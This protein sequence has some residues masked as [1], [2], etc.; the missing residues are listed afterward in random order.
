MVGG[1]WI[2]SWLVAWLVEEGR[3]WGLGRGEVS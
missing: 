2:G 3:W 1:E